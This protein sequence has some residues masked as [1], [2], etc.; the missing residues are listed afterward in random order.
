[1]NGKYGDSR[2]IVNTYNIV[3]NNI[4]RPQAYTN[5]GSC[6]RRCIAEMYGELQKNIREQLKALETIDEILTPT[7]E[8]LTNINAEKELNN[9]KQEEKK[10]KKTKKKQLNMFN[11]KH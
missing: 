4:K 9:V 3:F 10:Q 6:L 1:M 5:C 2:D 8:E 7:K 11:L